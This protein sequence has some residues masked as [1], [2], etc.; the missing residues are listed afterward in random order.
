MCL[1][2]LAAIVEDAQAAGREVEFVEPAE[3]VAR[4]YLSQMRLPEVLDVCGVEH[5]LPPVP[6]DAL[7]DRLTGL[8]SFGGDTS[9][10]DLAETAHRAFR[11]A[12]API[13][14][15]LYQ[16]VLEVADNV[17]TH[18]VVAHGYLAL[19]RF[20]RSG[21]VAFAIAD[22]GVGLR[23]TLSTRYECPDDVTAVS[24]AIRRRISGVDESRGLGLPSVLRAT[25]QLGGV[26][27]L[28]SGT[29]HGAFRRVGEDPVFRSSTTPLPGTVAYVRLRPVEG[30]MR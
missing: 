4:N 30:S 9:A 17:L 3:S 13:A 19:E 5:H 29:A 18:S 21:E 28:W 11:T 8:R 26:M 20:P 24:L 1:V 2:T 7:Q 6:K 15:A 23:T 10:D 22:A 27:H 14:D 12:D 25:E 16:S